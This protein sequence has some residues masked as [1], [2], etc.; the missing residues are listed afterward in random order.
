ME[1]KPIYIQSVL[2]NETPHQTQFCNMFQIEQ[3]NTTKAS[4]GQ[5]SNKTTEYKKGSLSRAPFFAA[6]LMGSHSSQ[7]NPVC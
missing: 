3:Y 1:E 5:P 2:N 6:A 7:S 4:Q